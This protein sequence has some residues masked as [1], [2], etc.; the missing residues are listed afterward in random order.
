MSKRVYRSPRGKRIRDLESAWRRLP[1][2]ASN[3]IARIV[4]LLTD[5]TALQQ[6]KAGQLLRAWRD[7]LDGPLSV[8]RVV[9]LIDEGLL[10]I[11]AVTDDDE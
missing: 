8:E 4:A 3:L 9:D 1:P 6:Y 11:E 2:R 7:A 10:A 5:G